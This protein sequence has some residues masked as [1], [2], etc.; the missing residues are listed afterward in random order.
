MCSRLPGRVPAGRRLELGGAVSV[1][2]GVAKGGAVVGH[3]RV[4]AQNV[5]VLGTLWA[6]IATCSGPC[7]IELV[8]ASRFVLI[9]EE[10]LEPPINKEFRMRLRQV[11][12]RGEGEV[13]SLPRG[14][15]TGR[16]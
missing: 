3:V 4:G 2:D 10:G 8:C 5:R 7:C 9:C 1:V 15:V 6:G 12:A 14:T 13:S 11:E 16:F